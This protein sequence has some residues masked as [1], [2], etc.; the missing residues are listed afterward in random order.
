MDEKDF[1]V[2]ENEQFTQLVIDT[3]ESWP[4]CCRIFYRDH[5]ES[6]VNG[7]FFIKI[8]VNRIVKHVIIYSNF[9][10]NLQNK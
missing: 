5:S 1:D 3:F 7:T 8:I 2:G 6:I 10:K 9:K 4:D